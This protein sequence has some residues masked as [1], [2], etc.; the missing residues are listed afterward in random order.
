MSLRLPEKYRAPL[1]LCYF[2]DKTNEEAATL[3]GCPLGTVATRLARARELLRRRLVNRGLALSAATLGAA[4]AQEA[5]AT[6]PSALTAAALKTAALAATAGVVAIEGV[7]A[8]VLMLA[9][10]AAGALVR[11][12]LKFVTVVLLAVTMAGAGIGA[13]GRYYRTRDPSGGSEAGDP[14]A[15]AVLPGQIRAALVWTERR[16]LEV[17][18]GRGAVHA[19]AL[20][21]DAMTLASAGTLNQ[22]QRQGEGP[23]TLDSA[24]KIWDLAR[25]GEPHTLDGSRPGRG[26]SNMRALVFSPDG[27]TLASAGD[28]LTLWNVATHRPRATVEEGR[29]AQAVAFAPDGQT[30]AWGR[31]DGAVGI[32]E[33]ATGRVRVTVPAHSDEVVC[34]RFSADGKTL[35]TIGREGT[36]KA[37]DAATTTLRDTHGLDV[38]KSLRVELAPDGKALALVG[39][40][41]ITPKLWYAASGRVRT[42]TPRRDADYPLAAISFAPD[43]KTIASGH[44]DGTVTLWDVATG[45]ELTTLDGHEAQVTTLAFS[46]DGRTLASGDQEG[47]V[48]VWAAQDQ[49]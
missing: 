23:P 34:L 30:L 38:S 39:I 8:Q 43:G 26:G 4:L 49:R 16:K 3:L 17:L 35:F 40:A 5:G 37:W 1:L 22:P 19:L 10:G 25:G 15:D 45:K 29:S 47:I 33:V 12:R 20:T 21:P 24:V 27:K 42:F 11:D 18:S 31:P 14:Q 13:L 28:S 41:D 7:S 46:A 48:K 6:V 32:L 9:Q 2:Q 44:V 36:M